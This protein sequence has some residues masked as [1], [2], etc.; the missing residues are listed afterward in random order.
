M[1]NRG[2]SLVTTVVSI[3]ILGIIFSAIS[4]VILNTFKSY[5]IASVKSEQ[6]SVDFLAFK[7]L[8]KS[9]VN[10]EPSMFRAS[11]TYASSSGA[12]AFTR[13]DPL[14]ERYIDIGSTAVESIAI[15]DLTERN[16]IYKILTDDAKAEADNV[17]TG[18][19]A[20]QLAGT[21]ISIYQDSF[22]LRNIQF[23]VEGSGVLASKPRNIYLSRCIP[24]ADAILDTN[25]STIVTTAPVQS[26]IYVNSLPKVP[27]LNKRSTSTKGDSYISCCDVGSACT[28]ENSHEYFVRFYNIGFIDGKITS[29]AEY[30][31]LGESETVWGVGFMIIMND[32]AKPNLFQVSRYTMRD[33]C[34]AMGL[35]NCKMLNPNHIKSN[36]MDNTFRTEFE[37]YSKQYIAVEPMTLGGV[38]SQGLKAGVLKFAQ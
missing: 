28:N 33:K 34:K 20:P 10:F 11:T 36:W 5:K 23:D 3:A 26:A 2:F 27:F 22:T 17:L 13:L 24:I 19:I 25:G 29:I 15:P 6:I 9:L 35:K 21:D 1:N 14:V 18:I 37:Q 30:P 8:S 4:D 16:T 7:Q 32:K 38:V 31:S 12:A